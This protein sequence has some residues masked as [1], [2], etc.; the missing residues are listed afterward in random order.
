V[1]RRISRSLTSFEITGSAREDQGTTVDA[2]ARETART[3][4]TFT[5]SVYK[6]RVRGPFSVR[7]RASGL[8]SGGKDL[9]PRP[10][11]YEPYDVRLWRLVRFSNGGADLGGQTWL[12]RDGVRR[13]PCLT[14]SRS[15]LC[16][17]PC[18]NQVSELRASGCSK[19]A[20]AHSFPYWLALGQ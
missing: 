4:A 20:G 9:N 6:T 13:L 16:T 14:P 7:E 1:S 18:T 8:G 3:S 15:V 2:R 5:K 12:V 19:P 17:N 11:G 10:L